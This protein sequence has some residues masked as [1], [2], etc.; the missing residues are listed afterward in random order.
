[1]EDAIS[2]ADPLVIK[3]KRS[4]IQGMM[5]KLQKSLVKLLLKSGSK[6]EHD[7]IKRLRV[8]QEHTKLKKLEE[9]F[10][11]IHQAYLH[12]REKG[13]DEPEEISLFEKE[14]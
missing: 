11:E 10:D 6:F 5:M 4:A 9:S 3:N 14:D 7:Q 8:Q 12:Y 13:K 2:S 1:M